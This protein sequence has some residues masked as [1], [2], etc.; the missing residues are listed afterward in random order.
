MDISIPSFLVGSLFDYIINNQQKSQWT[1][2]SMIFSLSAR[3]LKIK[4]RIRYFFAGIKHGSSGT[5]L[6]LLQIWK[7]TGSRDISTK[8]FSL[9]LNENFWK[10]KLFCPLKN[11]YYIFCSYISSKEGHKKKKKKLE[12]I[13][14]NKIFLLICQTLCA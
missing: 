13:S 10:F 3:H 7:Y 14:I 9:I 1:F 11:R 2:S 4:I 8:F 12:Q 5:N 6:R